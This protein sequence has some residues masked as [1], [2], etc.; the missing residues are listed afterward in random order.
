MVVHLRSNAAMSL[1]SLA[2]SAQALPRH[3]TEQ[4]AYR[5]FLSDLTG[6]TAGRRAGP[7]LHHCLASVVLMS[8][9]STQEFNP[10]TADCGY[11]GTA[12]SPV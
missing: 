4:T 11:K 2:G 3:P 9:P 7:K 5:C 12:S 10:A 1:P 6:F 8:P